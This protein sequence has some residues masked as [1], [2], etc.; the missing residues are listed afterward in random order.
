MRPRPKA[1]RALALVA[2]AQG[3]RSPARNG[4]THPMTSLEPTA[5]PA[6]GASALAP[7]AAAGLSIVVPVF[8]EAAGLPQLHRSL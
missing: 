8:N 7:Q 1:L 4:K 6:S 2:P 3:L 5:G